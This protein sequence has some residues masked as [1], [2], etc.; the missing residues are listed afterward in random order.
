ME[1]DG[2]YHSRRVRI[3]FSIACFKIKRGCLESVKDDDGYV[4]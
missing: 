2:I 1:M 4:R 3:K